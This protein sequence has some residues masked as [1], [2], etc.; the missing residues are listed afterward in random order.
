M[1]EARSLD[2]RKRL[3]VQESAAKAEDSSRAAFLK[4]DGSPLSRAERSSMRPETAIGGTTGLASARKTAR[5]R[6][7]EPAPVLPDRKE[8]FDDLL[9]LSRSRQKP[10]KLYDKKALAMARKAQ[11]ARAGQGTGKAERGSLN[12]AKLA[13]A[14]GL[15]VAIGVGLSFALPEVTRVGKVTVNGMS[16]VSENEVV[17]AL[18]LS[19]K[20][21]L[22]N[23][24]LGAMESRVLSNPKIARVRVRRSFPDKLVVDI[25]ERVPVA[26][27]LVTEEIGTKSIAIDA[28][29]IAFACLDQGNPLS[30]KLPVLSGIRFEHFQAGQSLPAFLV[31]LLGDI[32]ELSKLSPSPLQAFSEIKVQKIADSEAE[33][34]LYPAGNTVPIRMPARLNAANL[35]Q[36]LLVLDILA[37]REGVDKVEEVDFR[38]GTI[39]YKTKEAQAG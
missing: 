33:L 5:A 21:N 2:K 6:A 32:A 3:A 29:G 25:A 30:E 11:A 16:V 38:S 17:E 18:N 24:D 13:M 39:V 22:I 31:P 19:P 28:Q 4:P 7:G 8:G 9:I 15:L 23:A 26:C 35:G 27:V 1:A 36:A 14:L 10:M 34:L 20:V 12:K 37:G